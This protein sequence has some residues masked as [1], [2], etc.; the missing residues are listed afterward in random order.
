MKDGESILE[1]DAPI[2]AKLFG[3]TL[4]MTAAPDLTGRRVLVVEDD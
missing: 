1:T 2:P 3:G 4:D